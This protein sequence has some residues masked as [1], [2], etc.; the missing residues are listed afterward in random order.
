MISHLSYATFTHAWNT[1]TIPRVGLRRVEVEQYRGRCN[2]ICEKLC[3]QTKEWMVFISSLKLG[4]RLIRSS[5]SHATMMDSHHPNPVYFQPQK[6]EDAD[7]PAVAQYGRTSLDS[8]Q[9][10]VVLRLT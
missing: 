4:Y 5:F 8:K 9:A 10:Y 6:L 3:K 2:Y 7:A 1:C